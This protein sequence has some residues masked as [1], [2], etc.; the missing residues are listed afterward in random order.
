MS[1]LAP[2]CRLVL[3]NH[4]SFTFYNLLKW[5]KVMGTFYPPTFLSW[6][7]WHGGARMTDRRRSTLSSV[8]VCEFIILVEV[9]LFSDASATVINHLSYSYLSYSYWSSIC[10]RV[11][12]GSSAANAKQ[13]CCFCFKLK[14]KLTK[15]DFYF[16][17][18]TRNALYSVSGAIFHYGY[19]QVYT[20]EVDSLGTFSQ[21]LSFKYWREEEQTATFSCRL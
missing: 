21:E 19:L 17:A 15:Y 4:F 18:A 12:A 5:W 14:A 10:S 6:A 11:R 9:V 8:S 3:I 16:E 20:K 13:T 2:L 7:F 1:L